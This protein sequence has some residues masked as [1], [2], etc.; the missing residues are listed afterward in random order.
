MFPTTHQAARLNREHIHCILIFLA[1]DRQERQRPELTVQRFGK[2][3]LTLYRRHIDMAVMPL[4][5]FGKIGITLPVDAQTLHVYLLNNHRTDA[6]EAVTLAQY[7]AVLGN[8]RTAREHHIRRTLAHAR[9]G[10][11]IAA[12]HTCRLLGDHL[13]AIG[14]LADHAV[15]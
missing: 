2:F 3:F 7:A 12:T 1:F 4:F 15:A 13:T 8:I 9:T 6:L 14:M 10:I 5:V 11:D